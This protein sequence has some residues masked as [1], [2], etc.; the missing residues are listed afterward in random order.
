MKLLE[1]YIRHALVERNFGKHFKNPFDFDLL[2][3]DH[4]SNNEKASPH[5]IYSFFINNKNESLKKEI[6]DV[7]INKSK[8]SG[9]TQINKDKDNKEDIVNS[10]EESNFSILALKKSERV[11]DVLKE[12]F[13][14]NFSNCNIKDNNPI[15]CIN[16]SIGEDTDR[17]DNKK[18][19]NR[20]KQADSQKIKDKDFNWLLHD[21]HHHEVEIES[22]NKKDIDYSKIFSD[23]SAGEEFHWKNKHK[24]DK[25]LG[26]MYEYFKKISYTAEQISPHFVQGLQPHRI[27][28]VA[29]SVFGYCLSKM[30]SG[31][32][33][34][35]IDFTEFDNH[36]PGPE[37]KPGVIPKISKEESKEIQ[38]ILNNC[39]KAVHEKSPL[40]R[41][42]KS[43]I[44]KL[45][46]KFIKSKVNKDV[47]KKLK[48][49]S[50]YIYYMA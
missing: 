19:S 23:Y 13:G 7:K 27:D 37:V 47:V 28:D 48:N 11:I 2:V 39:Y 5:N 26:A 45:K 43:P 29:A 17:E 30:K 35:K 40:S 42:Q 12:E 36:Y 22:L 49:G 21:M 32:D 3:Y 18:A 4:I 46:N 8:K 31:N 25:F 24:K 1:I 10:L 33:A 6:L 15:L 50:I 34:Y 14:F 38:N 41:K 20:R 44:S 16:T 9:G